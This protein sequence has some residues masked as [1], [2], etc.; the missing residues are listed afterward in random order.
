[1]NPRFFHKYPARELII[2]ATAKIARVNE[3]QVESNAY[4]SY[5]YIYIYRE[6]K[7]SRQLGTATLRIFFPPRS[8]DFSGGT[9]STE[10]LSFLLNLTMCIYCAE[11]RERKKSRQ[12]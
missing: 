9:K 5:K 12:P 10:Y 4:T 7:S 8:N 1:M 11:E 6:K 3:I 2:R